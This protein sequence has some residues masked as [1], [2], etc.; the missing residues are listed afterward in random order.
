MHSPATDGLVISANGKIATMIK[1]GKTYYAV[2]QSPSNAVF[3]KVDRSISQINYLSETSIIF[4]SI[5]SGKN[6]INQWYGKLQIKL[7]GLV[8]AAPVTIRVD[9]VKN[10]L[11]VTPPLVNLTSWSTIN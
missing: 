5:M 4:S 10:N 7:T 11:A 1:N 2:I 6:S 8:K 3:E 9:F